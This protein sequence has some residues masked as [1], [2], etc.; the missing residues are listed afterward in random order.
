MRL[1]DNSGF[2][3]MKDVTILKRSRSPWKS[4][5]RQDH[6]K[7]CVKKS[8]RGRY[9]CGS[10][11]RGRG[12]ECGWWPFEPTLAFLTVLRD[13]NWKT[14]E[15]RGERIERARARNFD[16]AAIKEPSKLHVYHHL[17]NRKNE[18]ESI[19]RNALKRTATE[20]TTEIKRIKRKGN[21]YT[22]HKLFRLASV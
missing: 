2:Q 15:G 9:A 10:H 4:R 19:Y 16:R 20:E 7:S 11:G 8:G 18:D 3:T 13:P 14:K 5:C 12:P 17:E 21:G 6:R 22:E 1:T